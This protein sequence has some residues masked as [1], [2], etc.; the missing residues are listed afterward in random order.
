MGGGVNE[1]VWGVR[2]SASEK[3]SW[4]RGLK[5]VGARACRGVHVRVLCLYVQRRSA[6]AEREGSRALRA[7]VR[8]V[9]AP[10]ACAP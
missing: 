2:L 3:G 5:A 10:P 9:R 1:V 7:R 6:A 8:C 4:K